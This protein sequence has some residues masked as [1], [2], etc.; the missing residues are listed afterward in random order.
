MNAFRLAA[1][2]ADLVEMLG[3]PVEILTLAEFN[4]AFD[5]AAQRDVVVAY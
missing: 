5:P 3:T 2:Q 1:L 4:A